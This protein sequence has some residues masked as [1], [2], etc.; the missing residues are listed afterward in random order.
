MTYSKKRISV[1]ACAWLLAGAAY[2]SLY[3]M[4]VDP[5]VFGEAKAAVTCGAEPC[6][7]PVERHTGGIVLGVGKLEGKN[8]KSFTEDGYPQSDSANSGVSGIDAPL[9]PGRNSGQTTSGEQVDETVGLG[10]NNVDAGKF[11]LYKSWKYDDPGSP[12]GT[13]T[14]SSVTDADV[15]TWV[16]STDAELTTLGSNDGCGNDNQGFGGSGRCDLLLNVGELSTGYFDAEADIDFFIAPDV[17]GT[18]DG[19][20]AEEEFWIDEP[21]QS[22]CNLFNFGRGFPFVALCLALIEDGGVTSSS[23]IEQVNVELFNLM[24]R[25]HYAKALSD[26]GKDKQLI[27]RDVYVEIRHGKGDD[28]SRVFNQGRITPEDSGSSAR[29]DQWQEP[30]PPGAPSGDETRKHGVS[31]GFRCQGGADGDGDCQPSSSRTGPS[32]SDG[33]YDDVH[34]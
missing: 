9:P 5:S 23:A 28:R 29:A 25:T 13:R 31:Q 21:E 11:F 30:I 6:M 14:Y 15:Y 24:V 19:E 27:L 20:L 17:V 32:E 1:I 33:A 3:G 8:V 7:F 22:D 18:G 4:P 10:I 2:V 34:R 12:D 26:N 16:Y